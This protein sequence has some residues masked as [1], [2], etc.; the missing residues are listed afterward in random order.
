[1]KTQLKSL[2]DIIGKTVRG[3]EK[4]E[5]GQFIAISFSDS[6]VI[7]MANCMDGSYI[8]VDSTKPELCTRLVKAGVYTQM[9][10]CKRIRA[11]ERKNKIAT[12]KRELAEL[13]RLKEKYEV[14]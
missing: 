4:F 6:F 11:H 12:K 3:A 9:E 14:D 13:K 2:S 8:D 10:L 7:L 5:Y 1:M